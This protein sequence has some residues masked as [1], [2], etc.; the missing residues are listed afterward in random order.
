[1]PGAHPACLA[2]QGQNP[3]SVQHGAGVCDLTGV[4]D[5]LSLGR[6]R[7]DLSPSCELPQPGPPGLWQTLPFQDSVPS[8]PP[9]GPQNSTTLGEGSSRTP[10][11]S[12]L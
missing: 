6:T 2:P 1:M 8:A 5:P 9:G 7:L 3:G 10:T 4:T 12:S 11:A